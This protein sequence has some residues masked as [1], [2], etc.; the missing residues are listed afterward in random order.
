M[1]KVFKGCMIAGGTLAVF[2][3]QKVNA[4][5]TT[6]CHACHVKKLPKANQLPLYEDDNDYSKIEFVAHNPGRLEQQ[7][8]IVRKQVEHY[9]S[10]LADIGAYSRHVYETGL[11]HSKSSYDYLTENENTIPRML[12]I[13]SGGAVGLLFAA[14]GGI[15]KRLVY[16][17]A[18]LGAVSSVL[19][20]T[21][22]KEYVFTGYNIIKD[23]ANNALVS[24]GGVDTEKISS[25]A[26]EKIESLKSTM[27]FESTLA[28]LN[29]M[30]HKK[31]QKSASKDET[32]VKSEELKQEKSPDQD[33]YTARE[34]A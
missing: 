9:A 3:Y 34:R 29:E 2:P 20:P 23:N 21:L 30:F 10:S 32:N 8:S 15:F 6:P 31:Q 12:A 1:F 25:E 13:A 16:I 22:A 18:G 33:L 19:Y 5:E 17:S 7:I 14:R 26:K 28:K 27:K 24:Y 4:K 11:A